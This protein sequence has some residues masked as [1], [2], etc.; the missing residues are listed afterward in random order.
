MC[1]LGSRPGFLGCHGPILGYWL[2]ILGFDEEKQAFFVRA[3]RVVMTKCLF[4]CHL[5]SFFQKKAK[6]YA[7]FSTSLLPV[8]KIG[9]FA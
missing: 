3:V 1:I 5:H 9:C 2:A 7:R 8:I 4:L 6:N